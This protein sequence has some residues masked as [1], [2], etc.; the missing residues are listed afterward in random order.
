MIKKN[1]MTKNK[2]QN[3]IKNKDFKKTNL[4]LIK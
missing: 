3:E 1:G 2:K 4:K